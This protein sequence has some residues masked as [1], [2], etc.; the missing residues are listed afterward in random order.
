MWDCK[1]WERHS[2]FIIEEY[3]ENKNTELTNAKCTTIILSKGGCNFFIAHLEDKDR[4]QRLVD[5]YIDFIL[6]TVNKVK[7]VG[8]TK[9]FDILEQNKPK[10]KEF[11]KHQKWTEEDMNDY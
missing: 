1:V 7:Q 6:R 10:F 9:T 3:I 11:L 2:F 5:I 4:Y 8:W